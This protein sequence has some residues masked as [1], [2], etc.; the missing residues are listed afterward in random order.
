[1]ALYGIIIFK[2]YT[3][4]WDISTKIL[5]ILFH[6][7]MHLNLKLNEFLRF[8]VRRIID[9]KF[10]NIWRHTLRLTYKQNS[11]IVLMTV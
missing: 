7:K 8:G 9:I 10:S 3:T 4:R 6:V 1:M 2:Y 11:Q 5:L